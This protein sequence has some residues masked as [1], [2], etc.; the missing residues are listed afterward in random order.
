M[1][2]R[3][4]RGLALGVL[5]LSLWA[6]GSTMAVGF[7]LKATAVDWEQVARVPEFT[8]F[9]ER[10]ELS[11]LDRVSRMIFAVQVGAG[12]TDLDTVA[13][14]WQ[15]K[16]GETVIAQNVAPLN[17]GLADVSFSLAGLAPGR[18]D[19][20]AEFMVEEEVI[21]KGQS[22]FRLVAAAEPP[23]KG[24]VPILLPRGVS[25]KAGFPVNFGVPFPKGALWNETQAR[26]VKADGTPVPAQFTV[27]SRWGHTPATSIRWLG[28]DF[29]PETA[30]AWWPE[31]QDT[32]YF[33]EFGP[34]V[35]PVPAVATVTATATADGIEV[36]TGAMQFLV[37]RK[38]FNLLDNVRIGGKPVLQST[39]QAG[40]YLIDHE[41]S[42]YRA[43][44]DSAVTLTVEEQGEQRVT[45]RAEGWY[46]KDG[47]DGATLNFTLPT[48]KLCKFVTRIEAYAGRSC[49]RVLNTWVL[50]FDSFSVRLRDVGFSLPLRGCAAAEFGVEGGAPVTMP[51]PAAGAYL[52]QHL[53]DRFDVADGAG[54]ALQSGKRSA[55]WVM[56]TTPDALVAVGHRDTWQRFPKEFEV[57]PDALRFHFWPAHGRKHPDI[58]ETQ[59]QQIGRLLFAHQ[60][61][62]LNLA[63]PWSYY[64]GVAQM[65]GKPDMGVYS[66]AGMPMAGVHA[67]AMGV[68]S[69]SDVLI[70]FAAPAD[71]EFA[72]DTAACFQAAPHALPDTQWLCDSLVLG[73]MQPYS[74]KD[75]QIAE[76]T[77]SDMMRGYW[78]T[79]DACAEYGM[80]LY[81]TWHHGPLRAPGQ[82][83]P[84]RI[85]NATHHYEAYLPW[86]LYARSG[87]PFYLMQGSANIR[88]LTDVQVIHYDDSRY[89]QREFHFAQGRLVG[90]TKHTN[91]FN[92][93]G[94][95]HAVLAHLTCY[96]G[97][98][99]AY[100]LTGDLRL[101]EVVVDEWQ[102]TIISDRKN[103][104]FAHAD[105]TQN[106][107]DRESARDV[108]NSL[109]E[110]IDLY[111][112]TYHPAVLA[113]MAPLMDAFLNKFMRPWGLP[114]L[115]V[116]LYYGSEQARHQILEGV[117]E[118]RKSGGKPL[119][120]K[121]FWYTHAP[122]ENFAMAAI[123]NPQSNAQVEAW[124]S[125]QVTVMRRKAA[126]IRKQ[127]PSAA[128]FCSIPDLL[129]YLPRVMYV[130]A[131]A[132]GAV[133][134]SRLTASQPMPIED[135]SNAGWL[136][137]IVRK[138]EPG[139]FDVTITGRVA[140]PGVPVKVYAPDNKR[141]VDATV[142]AGT[143][144]GFTITVPDAGKGDY[145]IFV[146]GRDTK[147][148]L[149]VPLTK[150]PEVYRVGY[151]AQH[152][153][154]SRF[155]TRSEGNAA[156][157]FGV[158]PH[159]GHAALMTDDQ[160]ELG[161]TEKGELVEAKIGPEGAWVL[162]RARYVQLKMPA[163]LSVSPDRW[164]APSDEK[165][166]LKPY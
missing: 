143:H 45:L 124:L 23:Q 93:W 65:V 118:Y 52:L 135:T 160:R 28:V 2:R 161:S 126:E 64:F 71:A 98:L 100:Y 106:R 101:R 109:G 39:P 40:L 57:L 117:E 38:N 88:L 96:N 55:G 80:W 150:L 92:T 58:A 3:F 8:V 159:A 67:S 54:T 21:G 29:Q 125:A 24:R 77:I 156:E 157:L 151:W 90:S 102:K 142:P 110:L 131:R 63:M 12:G 163:T 75:M 20:V 114:V 134:L 120:R 47:T 165:L 31:R 127:V 56:A 137:T 60:G 111:Q 155:F 19:V 104:E 84:Y 122:F 148:Y 130:M 121:G 7:E 26:V 5:A 139:P 153:D 32:R 74:P 94:G 91:G 61:A 103:P 36:D 18:Y 46:V 138:N 49:V 33:L 76:E 51:V 152:L 68:A 30:P 35:K 95:D 82:F 108:T 50:T 99:L 73:W 116:V 13:V 145:V 83:E 166:M 147:E 162:V 133:S 70:H 22:F 112:L 81:R 34:D 132:G 107:T 37:R 1:N 41:G 141:I 6:C 97:M 123:L 62:E 113:H 4:Y 53:P 158:Q 25:A 87:D 140:E 15:V 48:D 69:T 144:T 85:Y 79:Q 128:A 115:N 44:N 59:P 10:E 154:D 78:E 72:R 129:I 89:K 164:F 27:R 86:M 42:S 43:A 11:V 119:D 146:K 136:R 14:N 149:F 17:K 9:V 105:R 16:Q 66:P